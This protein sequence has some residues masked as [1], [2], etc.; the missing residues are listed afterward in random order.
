[1]RKILAAISLA[2]VASA[3]AVA[4]DT[5]LAAF[6]HARGYRV[7]INPGSFSM[8]GDIYPDKNRVGLG[9]L[10]Q[11]K[12]C[13]SDLAVPEPEELENSTNVLSYGASDSSL[14]L[15]FAKSQSSGAASAHDL[16][17]G[18]AAQH[19]RFVV[20][21]ATDLVHVSISTGVVAEKATG[22]RCRAALL[23]QG[24]YLVTDAIGASTLNY[25]FL[26]AN[27]RSVGVDVAALAPLLFKLGLSK[28]QTTVGSASFE[29]PVFIGFG[30]AQ[31]DGKVFRLR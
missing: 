24:N 8:V 5:P 14:L 13:F 4:A 19:V 7:R 6:I 22:S 3:P 10:F 17:A 28:S 31:W 9:R 1:M 23:E 18:L 16:E 30:L 29:K 15:N 2:L 26:D 20:L 27:K 25:D 21:K 11:L 12:D